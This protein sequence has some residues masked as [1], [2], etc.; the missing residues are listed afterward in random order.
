MTMNHTKEQL[1][2]LYGKVPEDIQSIIRDENLGPAIQVIGKDHGITPAQALDVEDVVLH[3]LLGIKPAHSFAK[4]IQEKLNISEDVAQKIAKDIDENI[5]SPVKESLNKI[6]GTEKPERAIK[7]P[8][9][10]PV[11]PSA[12]TDPKETPRIPQAPTPRKP[13]PAQP[14]TLPSK[15]VNKKPMPH[16]GIVTQTPSPTPATPPTH[17]KSIVGA[18]KIGVGIPSAEHMFEQKLRETAPPIQ[19]DKPAEKLVD[20][21]DYGGKEDPY[22]ETTD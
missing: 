9:T 18:E 5:F 7:I 3:T 17:R 4:Q 22:R 6:Q 12:T 14:S 13:E 8:I 19:K 2:E 11:H 21:P 16:E 10:P 20:V 15:I 1:F